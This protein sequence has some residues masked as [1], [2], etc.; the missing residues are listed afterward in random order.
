[1]AEVVR[2]SRVG[3]WSEEDEHGVRSMVRTL[4]KQGQIEPLQVHE[5]DGKLMPFREDPW[6]N[7]IVRAIRRLDWDTILI[8]RMAR[9][10]P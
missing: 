5:V 7:C 9:Y 8:V 1:M 3:T 10:E 2:T 6:G 4:L